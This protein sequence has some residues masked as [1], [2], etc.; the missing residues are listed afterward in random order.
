MLADGAPYPFGK[1]GRWEAA[2]LAVG[3]TGHRDRG[4]AQDVGGQLQLPGPDSFQP[5]APGGVQR[6]GLAGGQ[7]QQAKAGAGAAEGVQQSAQARRLLAWPGRHHQDVA[8][9]WSGPLVLAPGTVSGAAVGT[10]VIEYSLRLKLT[11]MAGGDEIRL[12]G[13]GVRC[14]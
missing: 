11:K 10:E 12:H 8:C 1:L 4:H 3:V 2:E 7:A 9:P 6:G 13:A 14:S 5:R